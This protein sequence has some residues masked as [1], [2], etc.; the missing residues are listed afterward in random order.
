[1]H[2]T[3][4]QSKEQTKKK[5]TGQIA[6]EASRQN[7]ITNRETITHDRKQK[8]TKYTHNQTLTT[9]NISTNRGTTQRSK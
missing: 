3:K 4:T 6:K 1:M 9:N 2:K 8:A 5:E 7:K